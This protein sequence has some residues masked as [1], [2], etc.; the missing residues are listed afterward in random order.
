M[1]THLFFDL[2]GVLGS[3]GWGSEQRDLA[4]LEVAP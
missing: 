2:G 1:I 3:S 4:A